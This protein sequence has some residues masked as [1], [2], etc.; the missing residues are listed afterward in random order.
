MAAPKQWTRNQEKE[1]GDVIYHW[2]NNQNL[3][4]GVK[5]NEAGV[6]NRYSV[7]M[8]DKKNYGGAPISNRRKILGGGN[9]KQEVR[10]AVVS[11]MKE[12]PE[13][14]RRD[15]ESLGRMLRSI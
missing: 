2:I 10:K 6:S 8:V 5:K 11:W 14:T 12:H 13:A 4:I 15:H 3:V 7:I 9:N 1:K